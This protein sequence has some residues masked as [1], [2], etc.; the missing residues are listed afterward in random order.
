V[1]AGVVGVVA[2]PVAEDG[3]EGPDVEGDDGAVVGALPEGDE[4]AGWSR[5][6]SQPAPRAIA[7]AAIRIVRRIHFSF[8]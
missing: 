3:D 8:A 5:S 1:G 7:A 6:R 2:P 4:R